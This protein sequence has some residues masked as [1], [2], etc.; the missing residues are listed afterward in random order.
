ML[1]NEAIKV[2]KF[3]SCESIGAIHKTVLIHI[4]RRVIVSRSDF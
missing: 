1:P 2:F 3:S 4:E